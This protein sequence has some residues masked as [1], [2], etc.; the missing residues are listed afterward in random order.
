[1]DWAA[2][3]RPRCPAPSNPKPDHDDLAGRDCQP[4]GPQNQAITKIP[5]PNIPPPPPQRS[6]HFRA[7]H[8][9][10]ASEHEAFGSLALMSGHTSRAHSEIL[11]ILQARQ[12]PPPP[13]PPPPGGRIWNITVMLSS[14]VI[15]PRSCR[16]T[17]TRSTG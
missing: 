7:A 5:P 4:D 2:A 17:A 16:P 8:A 11:P 13:P 15:I 1:M 10:I 12:S 9:R 6:E 14:T 3:G